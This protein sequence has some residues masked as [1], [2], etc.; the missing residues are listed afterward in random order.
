MREHTLAAT[1]ALAVD[2]GN[3]GV[4][5]TG[6]DRDDVLVR[7]QVTTW[8]G[9]EDEAQAHQREIEIRTDGVIRAEGPRDRGTTWRV[10]YEIFA[11]RHT[12][13]ELDGRNGGLV[14]TDLA[15]DIDFETTNGGVVL[16]GLAGDVRGRTT[17]GG[18]VVRLTGS[19]WDGEGLDV[20][21]TNG[22]VQIRAPK[23]YSARFEASTTNGGVHIG[24][25]VTVQ[26]RFGGGDVSATLGEG[27]RARRRTA[28]CT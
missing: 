19:T 20:G 26:G 15:G 8:G 9:D 23:E 21:T 10:S 28:A 3:G 2:A 12:D 18:V 27:G 14:L 5:V 1:G 17:N 6:W 24:F 4:H 16:S 11:P 25:P 22:G 7:A 13:L